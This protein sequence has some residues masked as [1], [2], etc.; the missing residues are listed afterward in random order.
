MIKVLNVISDSNIGGAGRCIL[1]FLKYY[2]REKF[3]VDVVVPRGSLLGPEIEKLDT[4]VIEID[5]IADKSLDLKA[6]GKLNRVIKEVNPQIVHTH[7][8]VT[9]RI[10]GRLCGKKVVYT[11]HSVFPVS[12]KMKKGI[13]RFINKT[14]NEFLA[15]DIIAVAEAAKKNLTDAGISPNKIKVILN[16]VE[17]VT[18]LNEEEIQVEKTKFGICAGQTVIG[19]LARIEE[20]KGHRYLIEAAEK[21]KE[22]GKNF[23]VL[24]AGV[25]SMEEDLKHL[26]KEKQLEDTVIFVGFVQD[27]RRILSLL[28]IQANA[29]FGTEAT[30]LALLEG[31]SLGIPAV[32][33]NYGGNPG[34][35]THGENGY[36]F[37]S[38]DSAD[39]AKYLEQ[40]MDDNNGYQRM[41]KKCHEIF[42]KKF[43]AN[44]YARNIEKVYEGLLR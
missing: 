26:V 9:G 29:S 7:G 24:I 21:L 27:V 6:I 40:L 18:P 42:Q 11:R 36:L 43:T 1:N 30:S 34:V 4:K 13:G 12:P 44:I 28:D 19:I 22:N 10:C 35:I 32:V 8:T 2:D 41:V 23:K 38:Q 33:S 14:I 31:M 16:G 17:Q 15:D 39:M 25:G 20:V 37:Q 5:G 3:E